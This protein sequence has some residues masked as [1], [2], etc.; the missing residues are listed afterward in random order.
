MPT[1]FNG[2]ADLN[3]CL[4]CEAKDTRL[5]NISEENPNRLLAAQDFQ[6]AKSKPVT[7]NG[8]V[9][10]TVE[11]VIPDQLPP[12]TPVDSGERIHVVWSLTLT[13]DGSGGRRAE[14]EYILSV[15]N[16]DGSIRQ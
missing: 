7:M 13:A 11:L 4:K 9:T 6:L 12:S 14:T 3:V 10:E 16:A 2:T 15:E 5:F 1:R 8:Q